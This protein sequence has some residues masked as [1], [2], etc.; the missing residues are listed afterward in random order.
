MSISSGF[1][2]FVSAVFGPVVDMNEAM[3]KLGLFAVLLV[4][5]LKG[6]RR[7]M[8]ENNKVPAVVSVVL[9]LLAVRLMPKEWL[10]PLG[11]LLWIAAIVLVPYIIIDMAVKKWGALKAVLLIAMYIGIYLLAGGYTGFGMS[12]RLA[13]D[14]R[15]YWYYYQ[16]EII[17][18]GAVIA[19]YIAYKI[20]K[21][22]LRKA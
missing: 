20:T 12:F 1:Q 6:A 10:L 15:L 18:L 9:A 14:L 3:I 17:V 21:R 2:T 5:L 7:A 16:S 22:K 13:H 8:P 11:N 19:I 4:A